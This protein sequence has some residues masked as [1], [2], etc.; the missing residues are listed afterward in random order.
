MEWELTRF[1]C[2]NH[3]QQ[4][5]VMLLCGALCPFVPYPHRHT[6]TQPHSRTNKHVYAS[7]T[8]AR[9]PRH[10]VNVHT[11]TNEHIL[12]KCKDLIVGARVFHEIVV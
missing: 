7:T 5:S 8:T 2:H 11:T 3:S 10:G 4:P 1:H 9:I 12:A 6:H